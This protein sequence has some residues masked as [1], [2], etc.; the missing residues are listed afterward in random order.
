V[1]LLLL[2]HQAFDVCF[3]ALQV[4][5]VQRDILARGNAREINAN[6]H[7]DSTLLVP[8]IR[9][10]GEFF[11]QNLQLTRGREFRLDQSNRVLP[12]FLTIFQ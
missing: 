1:N 2:D 3:A 8:K 6:V 10:V 5:K 12:S 9:S 11:Y 7:P 4:G